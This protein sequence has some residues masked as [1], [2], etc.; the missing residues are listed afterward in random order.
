[1]YDEHY[2]SKCVNPKHY[3]RIVD[4]IVQHNPAC[5]GEDWA[6]DAIDTCIRKALLVGDC[7]TGM[8]AAFKAYNGKVRLFFE[9]LCPL[10]PNSF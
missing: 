1:M 3:D 8:A 4:L 10:M 5:T 2:R 7:S 9:P 6:A